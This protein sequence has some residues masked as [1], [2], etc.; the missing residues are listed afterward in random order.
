MPRYTM[1]DKGFSSTRG[2]VFLDQADKEQYRAD[3][4]NWTISREFT[5]K[6]MQGNDLLHLKQKLLS[7]YP[8]YTVTRDGVQCATIKKINGRYSIDQPGQPPIK[9]ERSFADTSFT[10]KREG[11]PFASVTRKPVSLLENCTIEVETGEDAE[12]VMAGMVVVYG[13]R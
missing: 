4:K 6:D 7:M 11:T 12:M 9:I 8:T 3:G 10:F 1:K 5:L 2:Y 13:T